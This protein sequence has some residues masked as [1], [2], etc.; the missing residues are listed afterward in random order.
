MSR[1]ILA[2]EAV[3]RVSGRSSI[4]VSGR[5]T[6]DPLIVG[7]TVTVRTH[8]RPDTSTQ[9]RGIEF[10]SPPGLTT[11]ALDESLVDTVGAGSR[12]TVE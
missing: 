1:S 11:I 8:G 4:F 9:I 2:V 6:G 3:H 7:A 5:L 12:V 10:H